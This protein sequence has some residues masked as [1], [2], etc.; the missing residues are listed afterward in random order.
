MRLLVSTG[1]WFPDDMGGMARV[2]R[3]SSHALAQRGHEVV[4]L[5]P[6]APGAP[7]AEEDGSLVVRRVL[8]RKHLPQTLMDAVQTRRQARKS[9]LGR[10][11]LAVA[12]DAV[13]AV[14]LLAARSSTP[15]VRVF[16]SSVSREFKFLRTH[17]GVGKTWLAAYAFMPLL[18][19]MDRT[20]MSKAA[21]I[22]VLSEYSRELLATDHPDALERVRRVSAGADA[23][24]FSA[25]HDDRDA[26]RGRLGLRAD[27]ILLLTVR[28][29]EPRMG[30][31]Q[32][33]RAFHR[34]GDDAASLAIVGDGVS[35]QSL[36]RL[37]ADLEIDGRVRFVGRVSDA[38]LREWYR[39]ADL[40]VLPTVAYEGFGLVTAEALA[41]GTPVIGTPVGA[42]PELLRP[43]DPRLVA[44]GTDPEALRAAIA[45][46]LPLLSPEFR[47]RCRQYARTCFAWEEV[48]VG[49]EQV[50]MEVIHSCSQPQRSTS[51]MHQT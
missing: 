27:A 39:A 34:L 37:A 36:R 41:S 16:H 6:T 50:L 44:S 46:V 47:R 11:D 45:D 29:L 8:D 51:S 25:P 14:G 17:I 26:I 15:L 40:F 32:L 3:D 43:L 1:Q 30:I 24:A 18:V 10:F 4:V 13:T 23:D 22:L 35:A 31:E 2:A 33:L 19:L 5:A 42:T 7:V 9:N 49:W 48:I 12:H 38:E 20:A 28:R 21:R